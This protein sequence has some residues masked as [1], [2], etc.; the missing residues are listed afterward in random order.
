MFRVDFLKICF[1]FDFS[2][3]ILANGDLKNAFYKNLVPFGKN[4]EL[5]S[6]K[7]VH[8]RD[9]PVVSDSFMLRK[10]LRFLEGVS[11]MLNKIDFKL[12]STQFGSL[13]ENND[14]EEFSR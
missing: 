13:F 6:S 1:K 4:F 9:G 8:T 14:S 2:H 12:C 10:A 5:I 7:T 11:E 3:S